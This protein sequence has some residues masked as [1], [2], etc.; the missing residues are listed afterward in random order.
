MV[1][2]A[3]LTQV[4]PRSEL[5][6][7]AVRVNALAQSVYTENA[8]KGFWET[9]RNVGEL[10]MLVTSELGEAL[11]GH[12]KDLMDDHLKHRKMFE[13]EIA[14]AFI[15]LLDLS[16]GL[17]LDLGMAMVEKLEYNRSRPYKHGKKY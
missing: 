14:D 8:Q 1:K 10:L 5:L 4:M 12:R 16:A 17:G 11:E 3:P 13:V 15:R 7:I 2:H 9:E 6:D